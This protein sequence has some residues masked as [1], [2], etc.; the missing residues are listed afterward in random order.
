MLSEQ[1]VLNNPEIEAF[2]ADMA[3]IYFLEQLPE[4][5]IRAITDLAIK[6]QL[7]TFSPYRGDVE[8]GVLGGLSVEARVRPYINM[9]TLKQSEIHLTPFFLK[10]IKRYDP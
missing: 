6:N 8:M 9:K 10:V 1:T 2:F 5:S 7:I 4:I 3:G